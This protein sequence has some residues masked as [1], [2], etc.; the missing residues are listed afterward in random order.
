[1]R[2]GQ[3]ASTCDVSTKTIRYYESIGLMNG[4]DR[5]DAGYRDYST[6]A[7]ER[8]TFIRDAQASGLS[9]T[10][11]MSVLEMKD[12]GRSSCAHT[13]DLLHRHL[14]ELDE[15][16]ARLQATRTQLA[17]LTTRADSL[18][19]AACSDPH[20]CQIIGSDHR[21]PSPR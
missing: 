14:N 19:P 4:P 5:T 1:M 15:Q 18:D 13:R 21:Q 9:L 2:I 8:L 12:A 11:I 7:V 3:L 20:R 6:D 17:H 16:I 10:E